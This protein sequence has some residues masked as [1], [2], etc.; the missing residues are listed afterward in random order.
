[1]W[2]LLEDHREVSTATA[3]VR[4]AVGTLGPKSSVVEALVLEAAS[5]SVVAEPT[6]MEPIE[7]LSDYPDEAATEVLLHAA[8]GL[9]PLRLGDSL[10]PNVARARPP[11]VLPDTE[12]FVFG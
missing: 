8:E 9:D 6:L 5:S 3:F 1:M 7:E 11:L 12:S 2:D 4:Q 10:V